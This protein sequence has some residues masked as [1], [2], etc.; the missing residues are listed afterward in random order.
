MSRLII[1][2][3]AIAMAAALTINAILAYGWSFTDTTFGGYLGVLL[4]T[5]AT[6]LGIVAG[7]AYPR[8]S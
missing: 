4:P 2:A 8:R 1:V 3:S 5:G 6:L 7:L